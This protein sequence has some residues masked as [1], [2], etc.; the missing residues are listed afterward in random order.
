[1]GSKLTVIDS[2]PLFNVPAFET[3]FYDEL[4]V[5]QK[6][7]LEALPEVKAADLVLIEGDHNW[8]TVYHELKQVEKMAEQSGTFPIVILHDTDWPYGRRDS[9][10]SPES[11]SSEYLKPYAMKGMLPGVRELVETDGINCTQYNALYEYGERNGVLTAIEDFLKETALQ[12]SF[13]RVYSNN[14]LGIIAPANERSE[15]FISYIVDTSGM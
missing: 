12:L 9:Y 4:T 2:K 6:S 13:H 5:V 15:S 14:G 10:D 11:I 8:Y 1:L 3:V 7:S